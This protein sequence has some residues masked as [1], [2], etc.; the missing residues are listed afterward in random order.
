M[1]K[2]GKKNKISALLIVLLF[3]LSFIPIVIAEPECSLGEVYVPGVGCKTP[4]IK[5]TQDIRAAD[6]TAIASSVG[7]DLEAIRIDNPFAAPGQP[8]LVDLTISNIG[9]QY[10]FNI[11][12]LPPNQYAF[13]VTIDP[14]DKILYKKEDG[15]YGRYD[16]N[17]VAW[18]SWFGSSW[19]SKGWY[20]LKKAIADFNVATSEDI[21]K[22]VEVGDMF[23]DYAKKTFVWDNYRSEMLERHGRVTDN[24]FADK[25]DDSDIKEFFPAVF[26]W[27]CIRSVDRESF[28]QEVE[29]YCGNTITL[30]C[31][32]AYM[33]DHV[34]KLKTSSFVLLTDEVQEGKCEYDPDD[35]VT[36]CGVGSDGICPPGNTACQ[37]ESSYTYQFVLLVP[38]DAPALSPQEFE[39]LINDGT[40][41]GDFKQ[42][43][44][45]GETYQFGFTESAT[46]PD[47]DFSG[48]CHTL[49]VRVQ[50]VNKNGLT[51][52][53]KKAL[54]WG[55]AGTIGG[56]IAGATPL[57]AAF[58][59]GVG[60]IKGIMVWGD[61]EL[62]GAPIYEGQGIFYVVAPAL[63]VAALFTLWLAIAAGTVGTLY[64]TRR[65][66]G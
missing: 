14:V 50:A 31:V 64:A 27:Q 30:G 61:Y 45:T 22:Y 34:G 35:G 8:V 11:I 36:Y 63:K 40:I 17:D 15:T 37:G 44:T 26:E 51:T 21:C 9:A 4:K 59:I 48:G 3:V 18:G 62:I 41:Q 65:R 19:V 32:G 66:T 2:I 28:E 25:I 57:G 5:M 20:Y 55:G 7:G 47:D 58:G 39:S 53:F 46:C 10:P 16:L 42:S 29:E 54:G 12:P 49:N 52:F 56:L 13:V 1:I 24:N 33:K 43:A 6:G 60:V 23:P 38:A